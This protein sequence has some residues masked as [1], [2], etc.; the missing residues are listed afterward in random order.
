MLSQALIEL[1]PDIRIVKLKPPTPYS[2][3]SST[4]ILAPKK[5]KEQDCNNTT[6]L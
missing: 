4:T 1:F 6:F 2:H 5:D 3:L